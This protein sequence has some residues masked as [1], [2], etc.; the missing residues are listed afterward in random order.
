MTPTVHVAEH[1]WVNTALGLALRIQIERHDGKPMGFR[2]VWD[3]FEE[4]YPGRWGIQLF[5]PR[6]RFFDQA[7]KYHIHVVEHHPDG[8]DLFDPVTEP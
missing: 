7:N 6:S 2:E 4:H 3:V 8:L 1:G 5:P